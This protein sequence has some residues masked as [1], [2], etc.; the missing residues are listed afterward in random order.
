M[1]PATS[2][3][4]DELFEPLA[5]SLGH[6]VFAATILER[7]M[8]AD[9]IQRRVFRD[10][11][12]KVFGAELVTRF[13]RKPA[14]ALL[15]ALRDLGYREDFATEIAAVIDGRNHFMHRLFEDSQFIEVFAARDGIGAI[16]ERVEI[17]IADIYTVIAKLEPQVTAGTEEMFG[18]SAPELLALLRETDSEEF[19][20]GEIRSQLE[21]LR[22]IP[23]SMVAGPSPGNSSRDVADATAHPSAAPEDPVGER[24]DEASGG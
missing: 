7:A 16:V 19:G 14:G 3:P 17:L 20:D 23:D 18:R 2:A 10:G 5:L 1:T 24:R 8:L 15:K 12:E 21:A 4:Y 13:E 9:L 11:A 6:L 22:G